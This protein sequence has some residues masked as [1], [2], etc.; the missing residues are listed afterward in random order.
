M[1]TVPDLVIILV[2]FL[3]SFWLTLNVRNALLRRAVL[4]R[5]NERSSHTTPVPRGGGWTFLIIMVP[6]MVGMRCYYGSPPIPLIAATLMLGLV[7][8][9]D[10]RKTIAPLV[11]LG[12]HLLA[13]WLGLLSFDA[14]LFQGLL[15]SWLDRTIAVIGWAWFMNLYNF[16]DGIDGLTGTET[17]AIATGSALVMTAANIYEP[18]LG[19]LASILTGACLGFLAHNWHPAKIFLGDVG[20]VPLGFLT[21]YLLLTLAMGGHPIPALILPL[22]Y[23]ADSGITITGRALRG[24]KIWQ[25]HRQHFYQRAAQAL[26]RHDPVVRWIALANIGLVVSAVAAVFFPWTGLACGVMLVLALLRKLH[27]CRSRS[28]AT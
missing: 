8:W 15:P 28:D 20:S 22:Y 12:T 10:D 16:M 21:G 19:A 2:T 1:S 13:A 3:L 6:C 9:Q 23:L 17:V 7:S 4:D 11:R 27:S 5:P 25:A 26:G 24:E 14:P 18:Y